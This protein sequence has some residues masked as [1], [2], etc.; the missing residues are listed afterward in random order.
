MRRF[1]IILGFLAFV[2]VLFTGNDVFAQMEFVENK[3]QWNTNVNF[4]GD[5]STGSF[6]LENKGFTVLLHNAKDMQ[7]LSG[8]VH[9][10]SVKDSIHPTKEGVDTLHSFAYKVKFLGAANN[11]SRIPEKMFSSHN[12]YFI[13]NDKSKWAGDCKLYQAIT[14]KNV[15]PFIDVRYYSEGNKLKYDFIVHPGGNV[16]A[17]AMQYD[18]PSEVSIKNKELII[19]T[20]VGQV[21][22]QYPYSYQSGTGFKKEVSVKY[23][24]RNNVVTF[25]V[26]DYDASS[27]LVIDPS[28]IFTTF[29]G[30][31]VDNWGYTATPGPDGSFYAGG[32]AFGAGY[33]VSPGAYQTTYGG[34][35]T[36]DAFPGYDIAIFKFS[37]NGSNRIYA[38]YIGGSANE[39]P[40]SMIVDDQG[41]LIVAG[42][43]SSPNYPTT[44]PSSGRA[45][46]DI[47]ITKF[48]TAGSNLI[49]SLR[50]GGDAS[51]G[52]NIRPKWAFPKGADA[53]RRN[54]G[55]DARS[56]VILDAANNIYL[57]SC[58]QSS[59]FPVTNAGSLQPVFGGGRQDGVIIKFTPTLSSVL[60]S[61]YFG[62]S[63]D[64]ACFV[65]SI[66]PL[67]GNLYVAGG[68]TS[69]NLPGGTSGVMYPN[70]QGGVADGFITQLDNAGSS[71]IKTTYQGTSGTDIVYGLKFDKAGFPYIMGTTTG[72]WPVLNATFSNAGGKQ[73][74]SKLQPDFSSYVYSTVFGTNSPVPNISPIAFLVDRCQNVYV[75]GWGGGINVDEQYTTGTTT[76]LPEVN[77]LAGIPAADGKDFYFF[78]L[79]ANAQSQLFGS[80]FGQF[81]GIGDHVDGG[82]SRFDAN[83]VV[84]QGICANCDGKAPFPT[85]PGS[86]SPTN[87]SSAC[88]EA[89]VKIE[90]N[91][92][93]VGSAVQ[94]AIQGVVN[95]KNGCVPLTVDFR[96]TLRQGVKFYWNF[97]DS[98]TDTI[99][100]QPSI[101][102]TYTTIGNFTVRLISED[103]TT[104]NIRDT[105]YTVIKVGNNKAMLDFVSQKLPPCESLTTQFTN[106]STS[107]SGNFGPASFIWDYGDGSPREVSGLNPPRIHTYASPGTYVVKLFINDTLFCNTPDS[108]MKTIRISPLVKAM[109]ITPPIGCHPYTATFQNTSLA[110]TKFI[111]E[112]GDGTFD[113]VNVSPTHLY[114]ATGSYNVRLIAIDTNT[115]N[116]VDTS[117][118]FTI[119][120]VDKP[121][122]LFTWGPNPPQENKP[123]Q[124]TNQ[125]T[126]AN[127]YL[128]FFGDGDSSI[129]VNPVHEY[130]E[131]GNFDVDLIAYNDAGCSDTASLVVN[132]IIVPLLDVPNAFTPG[133]FGVNGF[134]SVRGFGIGKMDFK[135]YNRWGQLMYQ[136]Q[137]RKQRGWDGLY[138]GQLQPM[139]VYTYTLDVEFTD[140]Q[141]LRKT[142]DITLLR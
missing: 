13:G 35:V 122:A 6:F 32:I 54:Y 38:T 11:I 116:K 118:Y 51:D 103:S 132:T 59:N 24:V 108:V 123:V 50:M 41:N 46:Y 31:S 77:P 114:P 47:I 25:D 52:V 106:T 131:T 72:S 140:G 60:F 2:S 20:S 4:R 99:T 29:T 28:I 3:G 45:G 18:G 142:G 83:G 134:I 61:T 104:C 92:A 135:I 10:H 96:D 36:E 27:T 81:G 76:G 33:P 82:T 113:S 26:D 97:G 136:S 98:P 49:G 93:G 55:D 21:T 57:A 133:K 137:N 102:H 139:D 107:N 34:G 44:V 88:N 100:T 75:S 62:G 90:M 70:N 79:R 64:D 1:R 110:G 80:H 5:F 95:K 84:Y 78:V 66:N 94:S 141:K 121:I 73:F 71:F 40:H 138:K 89:A 128:W 39:Q 85:T 37:P 63:G 16:S 65:A 117:A 101:S 30:S 67:T 14:Y 69:S 22:E 120:V 58:T 8:R 129:E 87:P 125:S 43:S 15:Y 9:G 42:R 124:F 112:F 7:A 19:T 126:G 17:I 91:F 12:N 48:N 105:S 53:I 86:W 23:V 115:C 111:W 127:R 130:N 119:R 56:E 68:T 109:F 74:I